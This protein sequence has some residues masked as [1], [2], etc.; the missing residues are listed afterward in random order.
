LVHEVDI[1]HDVGRAEDG[2]AAVREVAKEFHELEFRGRIEAGGGFVEKEDG[3]AG[4]EFHGDAD[5][6]ALAAGEIADAGAGALTE[7]ELGDGL[8]DELAELEGGRAAGKA[9]TGGEIEGLGDGEFGMDDL[10][11]GDEAPVIC[12][13]ARGDVD[14]ID[15]DR[16]GGG[17]SEAREYGEEGGF[18]GAAGPNDAYE[19]CWSDIEGDGIED[20]AAT[21]GAADIAGVDAATGHGADGVEGETI[22][23]EIKRPELEAVAYDEGV[24]IEAVAIGE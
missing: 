4:E 16:A 23:Q 20:V 22:E 17:R 6:L 10:G 15:H 21:G 19:T 9:E 11:L 12:A 7:A 13:T 8:E 3:G 2:A 24:L 18:A 14:A 5:A 1:L